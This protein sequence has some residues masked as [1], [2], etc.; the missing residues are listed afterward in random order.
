[1]SH[2]HV[3]FVTGASGFLGRPI[4]RR[5]ASAGYK[6]VGLDQCDANSAD[7]FAH[8]QLLL[9][10]ER[11]YDLLREYVPEVIVHAAG[12]A[13][14]VGSVEE[15]LADF[16]GS[17]VVCAHL[18]DAV[19]RVVPSARVVLISSAAVYGNPEVLPVSEGAVLAPISPYGFNRVM[20]E[21]LSRE[22]FTVY[23]VRTCALRIF[24]AYGTGLRRQIIWDVCEKASHGVVELSGTGEETRDFIHADCVALAIA[25]LLSGARFEG[26]AYNAASGVETP[27]RDLAAA[28]VADVNPGATV[29]FSGVSRP[30][31]PSRWRADTASIRSLGF[32]P[33]ISLARGLQEY[34]A[35]YKS[36]RVAS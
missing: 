20:C 21:T 4:V 19:R 34:C 3:A 35:W 24:S 29:T 14:V 36:L 15:P 17:V 5:L 12:P 1:M 31:D 9:P 30:G 18:L 16:E 25:T 26:E 10:D 11:L 22:Y 8:V 2:Q 33:C 23:G 28:L 6:V 7:S 32:E 13:S 27:I